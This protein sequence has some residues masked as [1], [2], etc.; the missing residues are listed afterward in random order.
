M[1]GQS[2]SGGGLP[3]D[4]YYE[5]CEQRGLRWPAGISYL[6]AGPVGAAL[7]SL[8]YWPDGDP[9][10]QNS[11]EYGISLLESAACQPPSNLIPLLPVDDRSIACAA[12][13]YKSDWNDENPEEAG[14]APC[15]VVRWHLDV[16]PDHYQGALLDTDAYSYLQS[17]SNEFAYHPRAISR[18]KSASQD[19]HDQYVAQLRRPR[20]R[21]RRP[22]QL[23]CQNVIVGLATVAQDARFDGLRVSD[24]VT[25]EVP[26]L[27]T[28]E[29]NRAL[30]ALI[31]CDAFQS[32]G[33][34]ELRFGGAG[35]DVQVP[36]VLG[37][38]ARTLGLTAGEEDPC[39]ITPGEARKLFLAVTPM[40]DE[41]RSRCSVTMDRGV[42]APERL[43][44]TLMSGTW[45]AVEL[46]YLLGTSARAASIL[47][48]GTE[49]SRRP[50]RLAEAEVCR[51]ALMSGMLF[52]RLSSKDTA[53][54][55]PQGVRVFDDLATHLMFS[56]LDDEGAVA[57][58]GF[59]GSLPWWS[60]QMPCPTLDRTIPLII[61]P[62]G[63][64]TPDDV[65]LVRD[66][67]ERYADWA[68][69]LLTPAD[70][71]DILPRQLPVMRCPDKLAE[72]DAQIERRNLAMRIGRA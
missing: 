3:T 72:L 54:G 59:S 51:A 1:V 57:F 66:L 69:A 17:L 11:L 52:R 31:L 12:C 47:T 33:T 18:I 44:F 2:A 64:P 45:G 29:A 23:A 27:A 43:C 60:S 36:A 70:T 46:A 9:A 41:L 42:M 28:H 14:P 8:V 13:V 38:F 71:A 4:L 55:G 7:K 25:C 15:A 16:I 34:M 49:F 20:K 26:H 35:K 53:I 5:L 65:R 21:D 39:A 58:T 63:M 62:R 50:E 32:G 68:I 67:Q 37:R 30:L 6:L 48:G 19:Y 24:F 61:V 56:I 40:P 22:I 10:D